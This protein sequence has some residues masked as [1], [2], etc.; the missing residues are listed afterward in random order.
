MAS[1]L[2]IFNELIGWDPSPP[3][4]IWMGA[5]PFKVPM[6][7]PFHTVSPRFNSLK[8]TIMG[9]WTSI[10]KHKVHGTCALTN[11]AEW[12]SICFRIHWYMQLVFTSQKYQLGV[13]C[14]FKSS[15]IPSWKPSVRD[16]QNLW[17][18]AFLRKYTQQY[19]Q[20]IL[21]YYDPIA[22]KQSRSQNINKPV[23]P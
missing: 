17:G 8:Y 4:S 1:T 6:Y 21:K 11:A 14:C 9:K 16:G 12:A 23:E 18:K 2:L 10:L 3:L 19:G 5:M 13:T 7:G 15:G 20:I 22:V